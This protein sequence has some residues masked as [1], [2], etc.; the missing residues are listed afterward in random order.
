MKEIYIKQVSL[1]IRVLSEV[2]KIEAFALHGGTAINL[3][4]QNMPRLSIDIDLTYIPFGERESDLKIIQLLLL[5]ISKR[6]TQTIPGIVI[7]LP[8]LQ[9]EEC[10]LFCQL[11]EALIK[12]EVN[13]VNRGII[14][15]VEIVPL[16]FHAQ[17]TFDQFIEARIVPKSQLFGGKIVAALDRQHPRD[18]FDIHQFLSMNG[19]FLEVKKG[20]IFCLLSSNRPLH[21]LLNPNFTNQKS[22]FVN[23]FDGMSDLHF[24]YEQFEE[25][26]LTLIKKAT[27][28]FSEE[29]KDFFINFVK[30][31]RE[32]LP[33]GKA[34]SNDAFLSYPAI[35]W[36]RYNLNML[37]MKNPEKFKKLV[38]NTGS[39]LNT[40]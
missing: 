30:G 14:F 15:P 39:L 18:I 1:L 3:F 37:K 8:S 9:N 28:L 38:E 20:L 7:T 10:K 12:L 4:H 27:E 21:E 17:E 19:Q 2:F 11:G 22:A 34:G 5:E 24:T 33:V 35:Q 40:I 25:T 36:K 32:D 16:C 6:L 26:R 13:T 31:N 29:D 23:Q